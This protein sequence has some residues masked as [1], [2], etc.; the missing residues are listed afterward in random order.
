MDV[1]AP[2][3][4]IHTWRDFLLHLATITIGLLIAL[5]LEGLVEAAHHRHLL[6]QAETNL[7]AEMNNNRQTLASDEKQLDG[8]EQEIESDLRLLTAVKTHQPTS[9]QLAK[10]WEWNGVDSSAWNTARDTG[11][12]ALMPYEFAQTYSGIYGQQGAVNDQARNYMRSIYR[13]TEPLKGG[14]Q[15]ADLQPAEIDTMIANAQQALIELDYLRDL[16][17]SLD[18]IYAHA[19]GK[20]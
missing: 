9:G 3:E 4:P 13:I 10:D 5:G 15:L 19:D 20:L 14:R 12:V 18:V 1:H 2:H 8:T 17:H 6:H 7:R 16:S 11:A